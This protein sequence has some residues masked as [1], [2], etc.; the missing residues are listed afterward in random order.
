MKKG[1][2]V[3]RRRKVHT[4]YAGRPG[5]APRQVDLSA[6]MKRRLASQA[7]SGILIVPGDSLHRDLVAEVTGESD[8]A[9]WLERVRREIAKHQR[10][11]GID[12][13]GPVPIEVQVGHC[14]LQVATRLG[15]RLSLDWILPGR[16]RV[17]RVSGRTVVRLPNIVQ[18]SAI[19]AGEDRVEFTVG[20]GRWCPTVPAYW[21]NCIRR[22]Q[23]GGWLDAQDDGYSEAS[24][25][26]RAGA[27]TVAMLEA[28]IEWCRQG[29]EA[30]TVRARDVPS[31]LTQGMAGQEFWRRCNDIALPTEFG[32]LAGRQRVAGDAIE[33]ALALVDFYQQAEALTLADALEKAVVNHSD[34]VPDLAGVTYEAVLSARKP[35]RQTAAP[36][37]VTP[38][39]RQRHQRTRVNKPSI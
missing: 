14:R 20:G 12:H 13:L 3:T 28:A 25:A 23:A 39:P 33:E 15:H 11:Q 38:A 10:P 19:V 22:L 29:F 5:E 35:Q 36:P 31:W 32:Y 16:S 6:S 9:S 18:A 24:R 7:V 37:T 8:G 30:G 17:A 21:A 34:D 2:V 27:L 1:V 26:A 4:A